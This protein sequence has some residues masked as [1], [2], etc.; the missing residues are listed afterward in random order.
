MLANVIVFGAGV[1]A[2]LVTAGLVLHVSR[3]AVLAST[4]EY[5]KRHLP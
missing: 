3:K 2:G 5:V 1:A 4:V